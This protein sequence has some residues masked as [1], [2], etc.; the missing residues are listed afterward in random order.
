MKDD[1]EEES[2]VQLSRS[3][4]GMT[5]GEGESGNTSEI[6]LAGSAFYGN[7][8]CHGA[9]IG[10]YKKRTKRERR[11]GLDHKEDE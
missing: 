11:V 3:E 4:C 2:N 6:N 9:S 7:P 1:H 5:R 10:K 8:G